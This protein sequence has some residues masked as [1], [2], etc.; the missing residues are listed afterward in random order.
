MVFCTDKR[1][2]VWYQPSC[3]YTQIFSPKKP[4]FHFFGVKTFF[5]KKGIMQLFSA[6]AIVK[7]LKNFFDPEKVKKRASNTAHNW[8]RPFYFTVQPRPQPTAQH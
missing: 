2:D 6:D 3:I 1:T 7:I 8:P 5:C 4:F